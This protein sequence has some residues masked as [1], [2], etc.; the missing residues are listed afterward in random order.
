MTRAARRYTARWI[1]PVT[2]PPIEAG[3]LLVDERGR[4]TSVGPASHV[5]GEGTVESIELGEAALL[6]GLVNV[7]AHLDLSFLRG[8][9]EDRTFADWIQQLLAIKQGTPLTPDETVVVARWSCIEALAAGMTTVATTEDSHAGFDALRESGMRGIAYREIF[10]PDPAQA[11]DVI[12][13]ARDAIAAQR[14]K[15]GELVRTGISPHAPFS[16]SDALYQRVAELAASERLPLAAHIA[17]SEDE[18][19]LVTRGEGTFATRLARRG[20][21]TRPRARSPIALLAETGV[22]DVAPL[23]IHCVRLEDGDLAMIAAAGAAVAHCAIANARFG[24]GIAPVPAMLDGGITVGLGTDSVASNNRLDLFEEARF[25]QL[26]QR[27]LHRDITLLPAARLLRMVT[28]DAARALGLD[29]CIG[30]LEVGKDA[31]LCCV[32][33]DSVHNQPVYDPL[34][35]LFHSARASDVRLSVVKGQVLY[36]AG[37]W[38]T[39]DVAETRRAV[40]AIAARAGAGPA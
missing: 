10:G 2:S 18:H 8:R 14:A 33:F 19:G 38:H 30:S 26:L 15:D 16:V 32:S 36:S 27:S 24:H 9:I 1:L 23:L 22:L 40:R 5:P 6:P 34:A 35:A 12:S 4:I 39:I 11:N 3:A 37:V 13:V 21:P 29:G 7:H 20:I 25:A 31:D 28:I 17:E